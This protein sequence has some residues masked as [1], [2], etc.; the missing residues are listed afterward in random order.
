MFDDCKSYAIFLY[1]LQDEYP[2]I[3]KSKIHSF[4]VSQTRSIAYG[5]LYFKTRLNYVLGRK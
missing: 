3:S 5:A 1:T 4:T 2:E